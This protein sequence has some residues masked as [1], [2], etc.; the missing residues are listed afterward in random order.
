MKKSWNAELFERYGFWS[1]Q[2]IRSLVKRSGF[3]INKMQITQNPWI[4]KNRLHNKVHLLDLI[5]MP[6]KP[7][8]YTDYQVIMMLVKPSI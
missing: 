5:E 3:E 4:V 6:A 7:L 1:E 8:D 2:D